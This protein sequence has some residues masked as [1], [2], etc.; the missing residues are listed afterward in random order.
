[1]YRI[2]EMNVIQP[3]TSTLPLDIHLGEPMLPGII[4]DTVQ[5]LAGREEQ[6]CRVLG[7]VSEF[8]GALLQSLIPILN[9]ATDFCIARGQQNVVSVM[10]R[11]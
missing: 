2:R 7:R 5:E 9:G 11:C 10:V 1:M 6:H 4:Q 3:Y 8:K